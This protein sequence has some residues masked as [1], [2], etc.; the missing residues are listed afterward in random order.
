[1][2]FEIYRRLKIVAE[3]FGYPKNQYGHA[4]QLD[5]LKWGDVPEN[6]KEHVRG[7]AE[8]EIILI[9][10]TSQTEFARSPTATLELVVSLGALCR[11]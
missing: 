9:Q 11:G 3:Q 2:M 1:M 8:K 5:G 7:M 10:S 4:T 6:V